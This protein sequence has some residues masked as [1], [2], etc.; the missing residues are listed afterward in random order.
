MKTKVHGKPTW[1]A[2]GPSGS[3]VIFRRK[4][5][6]ERFLNENPTYDEGDTPFVRRGKNM[7]D[8]E[9][10]QLPEVEEW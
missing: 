2:V 8:G 9:L 5:D 3:W 10:K 7:T 6:A 1:D 4:R